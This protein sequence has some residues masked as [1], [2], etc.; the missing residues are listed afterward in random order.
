MQSSTPGPNTGEG[1]QQGSTLSVTIILK[2]FIFLLVG[3]S[4]FLMTTLGGTITG[5]TITIILVISILTLCGFKNIS[6]LGEI[7]DNKN[8]LTFTWCFPTILLLVL[9]R[10]SIPDSTRYI[11]DYIAVGLG[12]LLLL[13]FLFNPMVNGFTFIFKKIVEN[14]KEYMNVIF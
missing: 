9:S 2:F 3:I 7:F 1:Q 13:N 11:T 6:N 12:I 5:Y 8:F 14:M 4:L 10:N